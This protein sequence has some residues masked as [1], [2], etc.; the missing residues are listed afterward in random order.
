MSTSRWPRLLS[1]LSS[2]R[3]LR[4]KRNGLLCHPM[5]LAILVQ[6]LSPTLVELEIHCSSPFA[7]WTDY[8]LYG[9]ADEPGSDDDSKP[10]RDLFPKWP[11]EHPNVTCWNLE[12]SFPNLVKLVLLEYSDDYDTPYLDDPVRQLLSLL[13]SGLQHLEVQFKSSKD[14]ISKWVIPSS[15]RTIGGFNLNH[16]PKAIEDLSYHEISISEMKATL[17]KHPKLKKAKFILPKNDRWTDDIDFSAGT[18]LESLTVLA[19]SNATGPYAHASITLP[20]KLTRFVSTIAICITPDILESLPHTITILEDIALGWEELEFRENMRGEGAVKAL[21]PSRLRILGLKEYPSPDP[22]FIKYLPSDLEKLTGLEVMVHQR[23]Y[24]NSLMAFR[25]AR[26][27][28]PVNWTYDMPNLVDLQLKCGEITFSTMPSRLGRLSLRTQP[29]S[30]NT[31]SA[32]LTSSVTSLN[33][34]IETTLKVETIDCT[35]LLSILPP[36]LIRLSI[37]FYHCEVDTSDLNAW[38]LLPSSLTSF[39]MYS[40]RDFDC[41]T[42][43]WTMKSD[44]I[45]PYLPESLRSLYVSLI[46]I[47][48]SD[49]IKMPCHGT[50]RR[51]VLDWTGKE[52]GYYQ[53]NDMLV[54]ALPDS[55]EVRITGIA[56]YL[57]YDS[58]WKKRKL[59]ADERRHQYPD[60]RVENPAQKLFD[61]GYEDDSEEEEELEYEL[62][63][64]SE[65]SDSESALE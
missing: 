17:K 48:S 13:P 7:A 64:L 11:F 42:T 36:N 22:E 20:P 24:D 39:S 37:G 3:S 27:R 33:L 43:E 49:I 14:E 46:E 29:S 1:A 58:A 62:K 53:P 8:A 12:L 4:I 26:P 40:E 2:L 65:D 63:E 25:S 38:N 28:L 9:A 54:K 5:S 57:P 23:R 50:L 35:K 6:E 45:L 32:L 52:R 30:L 18:N 51:L 60:P 31:L 41:H 44:Q 16:F 55:A 10:A 59:A 15:L 61:Y 56:H 34:V 19:G 21:W 47:N